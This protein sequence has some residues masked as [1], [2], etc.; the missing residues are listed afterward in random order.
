M[1]PRQV[2]SAEATA[3]A[4]REAATSAVAGP[5]TTRIP[6]VPSE[7]V[8]R[9][10]SCISVDTPVLPLKVKAAP[11]AENRLVSP[12]LQGSPW[13]SY[14]PQ[15]NGY[16]APFVRPDSRYYLPEP[17]ASF[18]SQRLLAGR[19]ISPYAALP[20]GTAY[21]QLMYAPNPNAAQR[22]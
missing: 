18:Y 8:G 5:E 15:F 10:E 14:P 2:L 12:Q 1:R 9:A 11:R 7:S 22:K 21:Y 20:S 3:Q 6:R 13:G 4:R 16:N 17:V 19:P